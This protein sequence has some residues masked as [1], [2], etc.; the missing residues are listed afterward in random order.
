V[1]ESDTS[2]ARDAL[3]EWG[4]EADEVR[5]SR[6]LGKA[7]SLG[8]VPGVYFMKDHDAKTLYVGKAVR[9]ADRVSSYFVPSARLEPRKVNM[10]AQVHD[11][12]VLECETEWEAV[13]TEARLIKDIKPKYNAYMTDDKTFPYLVVTSRDDFPGVFVTRTPND[14]AFRG[15]RVFGPFPASGELHNAI[16]ALQLVFRYRTCTL[17]IREDDERN[18]FFRPCLL[19]AVGRCSAPCAARIDKEGYRAD[20]DRFLRLLNSKRSVILRELRAEMGEASGAQRYEQAAA[21]RDQIRAIERLEERATMKDKYQPETESFVLDPRTAM[22]SLQRTL[23][24]E[25]PIRCVEGIDIAHL[26]GNETVGSK[27][28]FVDGRPFKEGYR[29]FRIRTVSNDDYA[30][31]REV[32]SRRYREAGRGNELYPDVILIDGGL[33]QLHA[34]MEVFEE[35]D[36]MPPMVISLAK[37]EE[38][39]YIQ[40]RAE[41]VRLGRDNPGLRLCQAVRDE[42]HR[43]AQSYHHTLR[44][45]RVLGEDR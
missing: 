6:L 2:Q 1:S 36:V 38:L 8:K 20:I 45:K 26:Q 39:I 11:F 18:R 41:P 19:H 33:G 30:S 15:S 14:E 37:K 5:L 21:L 32:V 10:V 4:S 25:R 44:Q 31:I 34:A 17:D 40:E 23:G 29:R 16:E 12:D 7:R 42:S 3:P 43:F 24:L 22:G 28:C 9:L 13:L 27:V 35:L